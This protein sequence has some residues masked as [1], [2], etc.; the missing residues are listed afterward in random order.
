MDLKI[1]ARARPLDKKRLVEAL[2]ANNQVV[3]V[4]GDG[5]NDAPALHAAHVGLSMGDGTKVA[6]DAS[7]II[8][9]DNSFAS[10][11]NAVKWGRSLYQNIQRFLLFQLTVNVAACF[12]VLVGAFMG[13]KSPLTVT[14]M[15][16]VNL[17]MDT[18]GAMALS[19]LPPTDKVM[20]DKPRK[21]GEKDMSLSEHIKNGSFI[22]NNSLI[23]NIL[24]V[25]GFFFVLLLGFLYVFQHA[26]ITQMS[27][28]MC[29]TLGDKNEVTTYES[30]LLFS[31]FVW[32]HFWYM[33][34]ARGYMFGSGLNLKQCEG[35]WFIT[36]VIIIGQIVIVEVFYDFFNVEP[37]KWQDWLIIVGLS[38]LVMWIREIF[39]LFKK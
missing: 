27:D 35:F 28:L 32:T 16:W 19:S 8:I 37:M 23:A 3:A 2:Q 6:Q 26:D 22:L 30:T 12:I 4:T 18:F 24:G 9:T 15:L 36:S 17:I 7:D 25:G 34:N 38:S 29:L 21:R 10:I 5:T 20:N 13:T 14:Q 11:C 1:I 31:I 33:F 39:R